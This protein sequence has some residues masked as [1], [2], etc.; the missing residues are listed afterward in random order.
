MAQRARLMAPASR[1][2]GTL[3]RPCGYARPSSR[4]VAGARPLVPH[5]G[6]AGFKTEGCQPHGRIF[7]VT[8]RYSPRSADTLPRSSIT[9]RKPEGPASWIQGCDTTAQQPIRSNAMRGRLCL[10]M[11]SIVGTKLCP[12]TKTLLLGWL[13]RQWLPVATCRSSRPQ[14]ATQMRQFVLLRNKNVCR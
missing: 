4:P 9:R 3:Y 2:Q 12:S 14:E 5:D 11:D 6:N 7:E 1:D 13:L 10:S 8:L